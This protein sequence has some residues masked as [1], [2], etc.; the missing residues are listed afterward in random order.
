MVGRVG[1]F[2]FEPDQGVALL[3]RLADEGVGQLDLELDVPLGV[4]LALPG[5]KFLEGDVERA[6]RHLHLAAGDR[7]A[8]EVVGLQVGV[9]RLFGQVELLVGDQFA[10]EL[11][12]DVGLDRDSLVGLLVAELGADMVVAVVDLVGQLEIDRGDAIGRGA[13]LLLEDLVALGVLDL[14]GQLLRGDRGQVEALQ[15]Q[16]ADVDDLAGLVE[17]LVGDEQ[18]LGRR[19]DL[20]LALQ[21]LGAE[22]GLR[23]HLE[24]VRPGGDG[25]HLEVNRGDAVGAGL[26]N[27]ER[28]GLA[29]PGHQPHLDVGAGQRHGLGNGLDAMHLAAERGRAASIEFRAGA[30]A[31]LVGLDHEDFL[32]LHLDL[33]PGEAAAHAQLFDRQPGRLELEA[34]GL[35]LLQRADVLFVAA[36]DSPPGVEQLDGQVAEELLAVGRRQVD[37]EGEGVRRLDG[38]GAL[39]REEV[40]VRPRPREAEDEHAGDDDGAREAKRQP[41]GGRA[42]L[43]V[44]W[45]EDLRLAGNVTALYPR[46]SVEGGP[47]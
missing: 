25:R 5:L 44:T 32:Q 3:Q 17:R 15:G 16:G 42:F 37:G 35:G 1:D 47:I 14:E 43:A 26:A 46:R 18:H 33:F 13:Q 19:L 22:A 27:V 23:E 38:G 21:L 11:G 8:E 36:E 20:H 45:H 10:L 29:F 40:G 4:G 39:G 24:H 28:V 30:E 31:R 12:Q 6:G 9:D 34:E 41:R 7:L 2:H